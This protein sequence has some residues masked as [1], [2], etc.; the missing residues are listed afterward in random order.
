MQSPNSLT[1]QVFKSKYYKGGDL[2]SAKTGYNPSLVWKSLL[3]GRELLAQGLIWHIGN[4]E[5][6]KIWE[7]AWLPHFGGTKIYSPVNTL[8]RQALVFDLI[9]TEANF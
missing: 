9:N 4:G 6:V 5:K 3:A 8:P 7:D 2:M 1:S